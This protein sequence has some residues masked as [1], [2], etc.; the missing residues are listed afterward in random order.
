MADTLYARIWLGRLA[1][2]LCSF[3]ILFIGLVPLG[4]TPRFLPQPDV[5]L[6]LTLAFALRRP[7]FVPVWL[8]ALVFLLSD[9][10]L[11]RP[12][13]LWTAIVILAVEMTRLQEYR[14]RELVFPFEWAYVAGVI[15]LALI[16]NRVV[17][18][19][20]LVPQLSFGTVML[21]FLF[22][23]LIYPLIVAFCVLLLRLHKVTPDEAI[24]YGHRL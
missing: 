5:L 10:L 7:D 18:S 22:T 9:I 21:H 12:V 19:L 23:A 4:F 14:F 17:L 24:R 20:A 1:Y 2:A 15:L 11:M 13:G 8:L 6:C 16:V 3:L